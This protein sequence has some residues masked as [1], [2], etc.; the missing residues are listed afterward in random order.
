M[1][2]CVCGGEVFITAVLLQPERVDLTSGASLIF[3]GHVFYFLILPIFCI[4]PDFS[5]LGIFLTKIP[6]FV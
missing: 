3:P 2:V 4:F 5:L 1:C 6:C